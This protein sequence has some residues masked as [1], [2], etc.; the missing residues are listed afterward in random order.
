MVSKIAYQKKGQGPVI[1]LLHGYAGSVLHWETVVQDLEKTHTVVI[2]NL[3][4]L[5]LSREK[6]PFHVQL[7]Q[8][9]RFLKI[10]FPGQC[11]NIAGISYGGALAWGLALKYPEIVQKVSLINPMMP[12]P[13]KHFAVPVL[14][15]VFRLPLNIRSLY[16]ILRT[17]MGR[18]FLKRL[19]EIFRVERADWLD[20]MNDLHGRKLLFVCHVIDKFNWILK[21]ENWN[22]WRESMKS[23]QHPVQMIYDPHDPLFDHGTYLAFSDLLDCD[24]VVE[25]RDAGHMAIHYRGPRIAQEILGFLNSKH[26]SS[27]VA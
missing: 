5:T 23:W 11:I 1:V 13:Q 18:F 27:K 4:H 12:D 6:I 24:S 22:Y 16:L 20:R 3:T 15:H 21:N 26:R 7:D 25:L 19:A 9:A 17:Q 8:L 2:P 14:K 10:N